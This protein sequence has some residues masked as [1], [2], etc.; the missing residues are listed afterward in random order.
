R[1][2][3]RR[4]IA[5]GALVQE[6]RQDM[7]LRREPRR[8]GVSRKEGR[9]LVA[10][11]CRARRLGNDHRHTRAD[12]LAQPVEDAPEKPPREP[13]HPVVVERPPAAERLARNRDAESRGFENLRGG[14]PSLW[15]EGVRKRVREQEDGP[16]LGTREGGSAGLE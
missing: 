4:P 14:N 15:L 12:L 6:L 8:V 1:F 5:R 11:D 3:A 16:G 10:K 7:R 9:K 13:E 2:Q